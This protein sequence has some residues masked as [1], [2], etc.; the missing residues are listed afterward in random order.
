MLGSMLFAFFAGIDLTGM[1]L[2]VACDDRCLD[3]SLHGGW[4]MNKFQQ[5]AISHPQ[6]R[7]NR[8]GEELFPFAH[9]HGNYLVILTVNK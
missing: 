2:G 4:S 5:Y 6:A 7:V 9:K 1:R 8:T 3:A